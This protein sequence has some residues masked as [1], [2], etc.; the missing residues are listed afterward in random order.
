VSGVTTDVKGAARS[1]QNNPAVQVLARVGNV[2]VGLVHI[3][4]G[5][6][7]ISLAFGARG[8]ADQSGAFHQLMQTPGGVFVLWVVVIGLF[9]LGVWQVIETVLAP[10][11]DPKRRWARRLKE[12]G[13]AV[14][15]F[16]LAWLGVVI[17]MGGAAS[18]NSSN[19][20]LSARILATPGGVFLLILIGLAIVA[21]GVYYVVRGAKK[22]FARDIETPS[23]AAGDATITLGVVG[24]IAKGIALGIVG[25]LFVIAAATYD[26]QKANGLDGALQTLRQLPFGPVLLFLVSAGLIA[27]GVYYC[28][29]AFV[30]R[31]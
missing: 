27:Y 9:A 5:G 17:A 21:I 11:A 25:V 7:G 22:T 15:Y 2:A 16:A 10:G 1:A 12:A 3:L 14:V 26:P 28:V 23:G 6:I 19:T 4:I 13:K 8:E 30:V 31:L 29:R 24:Y 18:S 20:T